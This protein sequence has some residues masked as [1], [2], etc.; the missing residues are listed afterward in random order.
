M[1]AVDILTALNYRA[2]YS[3]RMAPGLFLWLTKRH[4]IVNNVHT[5]LY[6]RTR[7]QKEEKKREIVLNSA[8]K[9]SNTISSRNWSLIRDKQHCFWIMRGFIQVQGQVCYSKVLRVMILCLTSIQC[10]LLKMCN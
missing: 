3:G 1:T 8:S 6:E 5:Y 4:A 9:Q 2:D 10:L 7:I